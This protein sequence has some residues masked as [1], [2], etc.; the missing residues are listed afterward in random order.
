[1]HAP[2]VPTAYAAFSN[3]NLPRLCRRVFQCSELAQEVIARHIADNQSLTFLKI[4]GWIVGC[5]S[6]LGVDLA[7]NIRYSRI[8]YKNKRMIAKSLDAYA[9]AKLVFEEN[10]RPYHT[11]ATELGMSVSEFHAAVQR[12]SYAGLVNPDTRSIRSKA[13]L[14][15]FL[16]GLRYVFPAQPGSIRR[17][18]PTSYA[19]PPL[20]GIIISDEKIGPIWPD[21]TGTVQGYEIE[22]LHP[23]APKAARLDIRFYEI[24]SLL[25]AV[26]EG[27][28]RERHLAEE[29]LRKRIQ[30]K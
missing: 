16:S 24:L 28:S 12:L 20:A 15:F 1:M 18:M 13:T 2:R 21:P 29:E 10:T 19:A 3:E 27:R 5:I 8:A 14:D 4:E 26:R 23:S 30:F 7:G 22:P 6:Y 17:G 25:D 9:L 11:V